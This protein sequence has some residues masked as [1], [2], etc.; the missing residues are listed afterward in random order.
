MKL[1]SFIKKL[2]SRKSTETAEVSN[3]P[4]V[5]EGVVPTHDVFGEGKVIGVDGNLIIVDFDNH[6]R[7]TMV[8]NHVKLHLVK[9]GGDFQA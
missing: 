3:Q 8:G 4:T 7:K 6:G 1:F 5:M 9:K 2:F